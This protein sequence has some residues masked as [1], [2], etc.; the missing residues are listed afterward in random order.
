MAQAPATQAAAPF[1]S[2][3]HEA[4]DVPQADG[5][6]SR[7]QVPPQAWYPEEHT[8]PHFVP[9]QVAC[10]APAGTEHTVHEGPQPVMSLLA[11]QKLLQA[12]VP[13]GQVPEQAAVLSMQV[14]LH[15][16]FPIGH[17]PP[18][19]VPSHVAVPFWG[20]GH[21]EQATPQLLMSSFRT[22]FPPHKCCPDSQPGVMGTSRGASTSP[23][24]SPVPPLPAND[25]SSPPE[26]LASLD[27]PPAP[28]EL[29]S[30]P[31]LSPPFPDGFRSAR[32]PSV[33]M[34]PLTHFPLGEQM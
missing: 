23:P 11:R 27:A 17:E 14:P 16:V 19:E 5:L 26:P 1:G 8:N 9:S 28:P 31:P 30:N 2:V 34:A 32:P 29:A 24:T 33:L 12:C 13:V 25:T 10:D 20:T 15:R 3:G 7:A 6:S 4:Q 18:Q 21:A 22:H